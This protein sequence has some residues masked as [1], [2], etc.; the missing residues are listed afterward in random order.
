MTTPDSPISPSALLKQT[1]KEFFEGSRSS[2]VYFPTALRLAWG[3]S[4]QLTISVALSMIVLAAWPVLI[5]YTGKWIMDAV[6]AGQV[7]TAVQ[8]ALLELVWVSLQTL[9]FRFFQLSK[10]LLE[11]RL[12][13]EINIKILQHATQFSLLQI[14]DPIY[15]DKLNRA[16]AEASARPMNMLIDSLQL[17]QGALTLAS[18]AV[19]IF[20]YNGWFLLVLLLVTVPATLAQAKYSDSLFRLKNH[21][22]PDTRKVN[23]LEHIIATDAYAKEQKVNAIGPYFL[24]KFRQMRER[25]YNEDKKLAL[26]HGA[27]GA[28]FSL[29]SVAGFYGCYVALTLQ[30]AQGVI[31]IGLFTLYLMAFRQSQTAFQGCLMSLGSM[32]EHNLYMANLIDFFSIPVAPAQVLLGPAQYQEKGIR[33]VNLGF[34]YPDSER[35]IFRGLNLFIPEGQTLGIVGSNG[36]GKS[37]LIKLIIGLYAATEGQIYLD[38]VLLSQWPEDR[39]RSRYSVVFQDFIAY[40]F[41]LRENIRLGDVSA[42]LEGSK[43]ET[44]AVKG[45]AQELAKKLVSGYDTQLGKWFKDGVGLS[46][47]EW[48]RV[49]LSRAFFREGAD[50]FV[51]DEPTAAVD[52][53]AEETLF[54][55]FR[56]LTAG[57]TA[58]LIS[59]RFATVRRASRI[60]VI[61]NSG[62]T[63]DG[64]HDD[65]VRLGGKY[66]SMFNSQA[67]AYV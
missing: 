58:L 39:L 36:A 16:R 42:E 52:A 59:H 23:Y 65:L 21:R 48:Q 8:M 27:F 35:W 45:G 61:E 40:Q 4:S 30:A 19:V 41:T 17:L 24:G 66:F 64:S 7:S 46:G 55:Q 11:A 1:F 62:I 5:A 26:S 29:I 9:F 53:L 12:S 38:G 31:S 6:L 10:S 25:F 47:G 43:I 56:L 37:T 54:D 28:L 2:F 49:A 51:F 60:I 50:I 22:S 13:N 18:F 63:E 67:K 32:Y 3:A 15:Y 33:I 44:A 34:R 20:T 14:E 57:K